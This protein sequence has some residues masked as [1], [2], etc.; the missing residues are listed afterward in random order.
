MVPAVRAEPLAP[1]QQGQLVESPPARAPVP[2]DDAYIIGPGDG[3]ALRF[4]SLST[5]QDLS[6][7][8]EVIS[9]GTATVPL[10]GSVRL[11]GL[12]LSQASLWLQS[13]YGRELLRPELDLTLVR[14]R[15][16]RVALVGQVQRPGAYTLTTTETSQSLAAVPITGLPT[17]VDAIQKAGG[18]TS[19]AD[20]RQ[21]LLRRRLPGEEVRYRRTRVDLLA[22]IQEGD[23]VQN[24]ILFDGDIIQLPRAEEP[25][26]ELS[27]LAVT[28]I[29][30]TQ[31]SVNVVGEVERPG[32][33]TLR[34]N[35]PLVQ[36]VLAA[37]GTRTWRANNGRVELLRI[38]RNGTLTRQAVPLNLGA[39]A[40]RQLNPPMQDGD[41]VVVFRS[42]YAKLADAI[43]AVGSP[44]TSL[45]SILT[46]YRLASD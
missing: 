37:G 36:A 21:V 16:L 33:V 4:L 8:L 9:D 35:T 7:P 29:A 1:T 27:E 31:I 15:P 26:V 10:L 13:L 22:L 30:P 34:P 40:S 3:L 17:L 12:T 42:S 24:P 44:L 20:L 28:T 5:A 6:G 46:L 14:P 23:L 19:E 43:D 2:Q 25:V 11:T 45:A 18:V 39:P 38:N 32:P 41:T